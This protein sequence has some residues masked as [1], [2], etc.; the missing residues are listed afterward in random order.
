[1]QVFTCMLINDLKK[2]LLN[3]KY[4]QTKLHKAQPTTL[5]HTI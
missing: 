3:I 2:F 5:L 4:V 1:M